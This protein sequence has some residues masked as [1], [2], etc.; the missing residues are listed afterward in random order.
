MDI[1][2]MEPDLG[3]FI[4]L[5]GATVC[6]DASNPTCAGKDNSVFC[7]VGGIVRFGSW[8]GGAPPPPEDEK[9]QGQ[10]APGPD[11]PRSCN[12]SAVCMRTGDLEV[13]HDLPSYRT[14]GAER[15][16]SLAYHSTHAFPST[17]LDRFWTPGGAAPPPLSMSTRFKVAGVEQGREVFHSPQGCATGLCRF[18]RQGDA[19]SLA[20]GV[21]P[22]EL[23]LNCNFPVSRRSETHTD[24]LPVVNQITSP[25][26][27]GWSIEGLERIH[28]SATGDF[29]LT[30]GRTEPL[31]F[32]PALRATAGIG[33]AG[34]QDVYQFAAN[35]GEVVSLRMKRKSNQPDGS[36]SLD[37]QLELR[38]SRGFVLAQDDDSGESIVAGPGTSEDAEIAGF[39]L[40]ATDTYTVVARGANA[41]TGPYE[42][43]FTTASDTPLVEGQSQ[44]PQGVQP[45]FTFTDAIGS[46]GTVTHTLAAS[47]GSR[48]TI[49]VDRLASQAGGSGSLD[50][51][52]ELRTS[53]G[54]VLASN[55]ESGGDQPPGPGRNALITGLTLPA[56]DTYTLAVSGAGGTTGPYQVNVLFADATGPLQVAD[57]GS[58]V[59][60][61][62]VESPTG[63]FSELRETAAGFERRM[64]SGTV[65]VFD[66]AGLLE[67]ATDRNGNT[68]SYAYD[69]S[70]RLVSITDPVGQ[71]TQLRYDVAGSGSAAACAQALDEIEDPAGRITRFVHDAECNLLSITQ[72]D[73][74]VRRFGY[75]V[76]HLLTRKTSPRG[77]TTPN[78]P[79]DFTTFYTYDDAGRILDVVRPGSLTPRI[80][81]PS[82]GGG[83]GAT[84]GSGNAVPPPKLAVCIQDNPDFWCPGLPGPAPSQAQLNVL[85]RDSEGH[86]TSFGRLGPQGNA[87]SI[88][89]PSA[90]A[91]TI[92]RDPA[93]NP[94]S[95]S[96]GGMAL[97]GR[98]YDETAN[99][100]QLAL[101][102]LRGTYELEPDSN[103]LVTSVTNP[104][105]NRTRVLRDEN[106]NLLELAPSDGT[107]VSVSRNNVGQPLTIDDGPA[108]TEL[109]YG[110]RGML[111]AIRTRTTTDE[112]VTLL[113][114]TSFGAIAAIEDAMGRLTAFSYDDAGRT[115]S[116]T[117][118]DDEVVEFVYDDDGNLSSV[119]PPGRPPHLLTSSP[120]GR[121]VTYTPPAVGQF[122]PA[123]NFAYNAEDELARVDHPDGRS[124]VVARLPSGEITTVTTPIGSYSLA[125]SS[126]TGVLESIQTPAGDLLTFL[127]DGLLRVGEILSGSVSGRV[128]WTLDSAGR[129]SGRSVNGGAGVTFEYDDSGRLVRAGALEL[130]RDDV[131]GLVS[132]TRLDEA[133]TLTEY[134][135]FLEPTLL[136]LR[137]AGALVASLSYERDALGRVTTTSEQIAGGPVVERTYGY[138]L[139]GRLIEVRRD[140][141][142]EEMYSYDPNGN[143]VFEQTADRSVVSV[144]DAQDR[145]VT[146]G[147]EGWSYNE[148]GDAVRVEDQFGQVQTLEFDVF[149]NLTQVAQPNGSVLDYTIGPRHRRLAK[150][151]DGESVAAFLYKDQRNPVAELEADGSLKS[152]FVFGHRPFVPAYLESDDARYVIF[153]DAMGSVRLVVD[154]N[155]GQIAQQLEY[156]AFGKITQDTSPGFQP[157]AFAGGLADQDT[158][159]IR[160]GRRE[161]DPRTGRWLTKDPFLFGGGDVNLYQYSGSDP[162]NNSDRVGALFDRVSDVDGIIENKRAECERLR[163][164]GQHIDAEIC[165][166]ELNELE[167]KSGSNRAQQFMEDLVETVCRLGVDGGV[168][169][170]K[171]R[172]GEKSGI[173]GLEAL[174]DFGLADR[175]CEKVKCWVLDDSFCDCPDEESG[176]NADD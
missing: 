32:T 67:R 97:F 90:R 26:G 161:Y 99:L 66:A 91:L 88:T 12:N 131:S 84:G 109:T 7:S 123:T 49:E 159:F 115:I 5:G 76:R 137:V 1:F 102:G 36:S 44:A 3:E 65:K 160:F 64:K 176:G 136:E 9:G 45:A 127:Y 121:V 130:D 103:G 4:R 100:R 125:Y 20:T 170:I 128:D 133:E 2:A 154:S 23:T 142:L 110:P 152:R 61:R 151:R 25:Y 122:D 147:G 126:F 63:E 54:F 78:D 58:L 116:Q 55:D 135:G 175:L 108:M 39:T 18:A 143:R 148:N 85:F 114:R 50:P 118:P 141:V 101:A 19:S 60:E 43:L 73:D 74:T 98:S 153:T 155:S 138:D 94:I 174:S 15:R 157:F 37:P 120:T 124:I 47:V 149:G 168:G 14:L 21:Y 30:D 134:N 35:R 105:G 93:G 41:T 59:L 87:L 162:V 81:D 75:D 53:Q 69:A 42:L 10:D 57:A 56:T 89:D 112:R 172:A 70:D 29:L 92:D 104:L 106:G 156:S 62:V 96:L 132:R 22:A 33:R 95:T 82:R 165:K 13:R 8:H 113:A 68:T 40:P 139:Q 72:P 166:N 167:R 51:A 111:A 145:L 6:P 129:I 83:G 144:Y 173:P 28:P 119:T 163:R 52:I 77:E 107:P 171:K 46:Q 16:V 164:Q 140:G 38:D 48:V 24:V 79:D 117:F 11:V 17:Y 169:K 158:G 86:E 71:V 146:R 80:F 31:I 34:E 27:A 150:R